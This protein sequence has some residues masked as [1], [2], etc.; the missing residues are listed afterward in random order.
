MPTWLQPFAWLMPL[1]HA[2]KAMRA[3]MINGEGLGAIYP[4]LLA[5]LGMGVVLVFLSARTASRAGR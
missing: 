2:N 3:V 5:L 1:T 4:Y